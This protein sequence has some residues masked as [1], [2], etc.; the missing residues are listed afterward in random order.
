[1]LTYEEIINYC[2]NYKIDN[3]IIVDKKTSKQVLDEETILK[4]KSSVLLFKE[5]KEAY[6]SDVQQF[7]KTTKTQEDYIKKTMEKFGA[8]NEENTYG[9]NKLINTILS[10]NGHYEEN[11]SGKDMFN[12]KFSI[13]VGAKKDYGLA[14]LKLKFREKGLDI[15]ELKVSQDL[16]ELQHNGFSKVI[17]DFKVKKYQKESE[18]QNN[19]QQEN[20]PLFQHPK[21]QELN[22][23]ERKKQLAKQKGNQ[24]E[25]KYYQSLI[26]K[27]VKENEL[28]INSDEWDKLSDEEKVSFYKIKMNEAKVF[29]DEVNYNY[30]SSNLRRLQE[31]INGSSN[32]Q[33]I[34]T[35]TYNNQ[36]K[37]NKPIIEQSKQ[38]QLKDFKYYYEEMM[39]VIRQYNPNSSLT[40]EQKKQF[41][42]EIFYNEMYMIDKISNN[43]DIQQLTTLIVNNLGNNEMEN[44]LSNIIIT[45]LQEKYKKLNPTQQQEGIKEQKYNNDDLDLSGLISQ[46]KNE[47]IKIQKAYRVM[48]QDGYIDDQELDTLTIMIGKVINDGYSLKDIATNQNDVRTIVSIIDILE[49]EQRKMTNVQHGIKEIGRSL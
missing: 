10:S 47:L 12:S 19:K 4:I 15:E 11:M 22:E 29:R 34:D 49:E 35:P 25:F 6:Q 46:L 23:L 1:M 39:K 17:I 18:I 8:N 36:P 16:S 44:R 41:I 3:G 45:E 31:K 33:N 5:A 14:Y 21:S 37:S 13:L 38:E 42:G 2:S 27:I 43:N 48:L 24:E 20:K 7:G 30:W 9:I 40:E 28:S 32:I 26:E